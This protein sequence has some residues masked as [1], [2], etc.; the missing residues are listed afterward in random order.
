MHSL[1]LQKTFTFTHIVTYSGFK[2]KPESKVTSLKAVTPLLTQR[3]T[4]QN[5]IK[6]IY[7]Q[8][9]NTCQEITPRIYNDYIQ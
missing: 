7:K 5:S 6:T 4:V 1:H 2:I 3:L 8:N 9:N